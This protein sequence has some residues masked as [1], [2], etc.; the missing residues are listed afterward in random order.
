MSKNNQ[1]TLT[2]AA[3]EHYIL[4]RL[5]RLGWIA[6]LAPEGAPNHDIIVTDLNGERFCA[7]QVKTSRGLGKDEGWHMREKHEKLVSPTLFYCFVKLKEE[8]KFEIQVFII[9]SKIIAEVLRETHHIWLNTPG[10]KGQKHND[11]KMRRL[12][13]DYSTTLKLN[14]SQREKYG[15]GWMDKYHEN[16]KILGLP[17]LN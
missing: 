8:S 7:I 2:G 12:L 14:P 10:Q 11:T 9:P 17:K 5:L 3:G 16:W 1:S 6:A 13:P 15:A 4:F